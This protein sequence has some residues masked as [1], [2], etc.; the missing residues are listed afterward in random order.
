MFLQKYTKVICLLMFKYK[1]IHEGYTQGLNITQRKCTEGKSEE[2]RGWRYLFLKIYCHYFIGLGT[3][4][5]ISSA[6][7]D[8]ELN[9]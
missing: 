9:K 7:L 4:A 5:F 3:N 2:C 1:E 8:E 6:I